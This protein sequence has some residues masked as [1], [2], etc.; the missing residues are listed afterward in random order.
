LEIPGASILQVHVT[1]A[2]PELLDAYVRAQDLIAGYS[3]TPDRSVELQVYWRCV[4]HRDLSA[5][6]IEL[7]AS[8]QTNL[9]DSL[10]RV[11]V[12]SQLP[13]AD[14]CALED[15]MLQAPPPSPT[16]VIGSVG[17]SN[18]G[19][20][21]ATVYRIR[22]LPCSYVELPYPGDF[23]A[24][25]GAEVTAGGN[26]SAYLLSAA[27]LE[28]GVIRRG[29]LQGLFIRR[30]GDLATAAECYRRFLT[31]EPPLAT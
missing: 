21:A 29:R 15:V 12:G 2:T 18:S 13:P 19:A 7:I 24:A 27:R 5:V 28:K 3:L 25:G 20:V 23:G 11:E 9:L 8:V 6:G 30:D 4:E 17:D 10:T 14:T 16:R 31:S 1:A 22:S 26:R